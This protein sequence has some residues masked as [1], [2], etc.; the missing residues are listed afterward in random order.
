MTKANDPIKN[1]QSRID[2]L[3]Q[4]INERGEQI[5]KRTR[6]LKE[7]LQAE[8]S[9]ME[10][11]KR[12]PVEAAGA[13]FVTG[14]VAGRVIRSL[15]GRKPRAAAIQPS[16]ESAPQAAHA[17]QQKQ[18]SQI[19]V[20]VGAIGVELLHAAKDLAVTWLKSQVEAKKK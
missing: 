12:H 10:M 5:R 14:I 18:P 20:A 2:E 8:L 11:L 4:T 17:P 13:S 7:D 15:F 16:A 3:E 9:P 19:G 1:I 6:Q